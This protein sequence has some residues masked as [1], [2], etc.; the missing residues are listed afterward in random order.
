MEG[1]NQAESKFGWLRALIWPI[2][3]HEMKKLVPMLLLFFFITFNYNV[4]RTLKDTLVV[5]AKQSGAEVIPFIKF[6]FMFPGSVLMAYLYTRLS[7]R[8]SREWVFYI[9]A[10]GFIT[11]FALFALALYPNRDLLH[12]HAFADTMQAALPL[13][14]K[15]LVAAVRNWTFTSFYVMSEL[16]SSIVLSMLLWG[17]ANQITRLGEAKRFYAVF[18]V[19]VNFS[20]IIA[21]QISI[22][23]CCQGYNPSFPFGQTEWEQSLYILLG[24]IV[25]SGIISLML[26]RWLNTR[27]LTDPAFYDASEEKKEKAM[28]GKLSLRESFRYMFTSRYMICIVVTVI[29]YNMVIN[30]VEV[31]WKHEVKELYSDPK[32][33]HLY[34]NQV[35]SFIGV[36]ATLTSLFISGNSIRRLGWSFTAMVTPIVLLVTSVA[37]FGSFV[38][39]ENYP[40]LLHSFFGMLPLALVVFFG[41]SQNVLSRA[42]KYTVF[43]A[44]RE[45]A[46]VPLSPADKIKGKAVVDGVCS[47][48]GKSGGSVVHQALL[49]VF[50]SITQSAPYVGVCLLVVIAIWIAAT[51]VLGKEFNAM[52]ALEQQSASEE[53]VVPEELRLEEQPA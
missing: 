4:L 47:R 53:K 11:Y 40:F 38:V 28:R 7:N 10:G 6:W 9:I 44:T 51:R 25:T 19:A 32:Q 3:R 29:A 52:A 42:A 14:L 17:F 27:V 30:L 50:S 12:P 1:V 46:F 16:W 15:G 23:V 22:M 8:V 20:G 39:K 24:M 35:T 26:F 21:G 36:I 5:N 37:F 2:H 13:G 34:M 48:L 45:M 43:D 49:L 33:Y 31:L 41:T 18:G